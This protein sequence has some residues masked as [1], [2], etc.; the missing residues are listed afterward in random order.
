MQAHVQTNVQ[1][2]SSERCAAHPVSPLGCNAAVF[3]GTRLSNI[4]VLLQDN[5][6][7]G[8]FWFQAAVVHV[9]VV[10]IIEYVTESM[11]VSLLCTT[12]S[13]FTDSLVRFTVL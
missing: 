5:E 12:S 10:H 9:V 4:S 2:C 3:H 8:I 7:Y 6:A 11:P 1:S 13:A